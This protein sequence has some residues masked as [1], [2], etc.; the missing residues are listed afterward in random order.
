MG[1]MAVIMGAFKELRLQW[2]SRK[3][4]TLW[5]STTTGL[6]GLTGPSDMLAAGVAAATTAAAPTQIVE[7]CH[8]LLKCGA[9]IGS[10]SN[11]V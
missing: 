2:N 1:T 5:A 8:N 11:Y 3:V 6:L 4:S 9:G 7:G 10:A